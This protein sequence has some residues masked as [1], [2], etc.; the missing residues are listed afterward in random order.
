MTFQIHLEPGGKNF[1]AEP[2]EKIL[3]AALRQGVTLPY[4]CRNGSCGTCKAGLK[5]GQVDYGQ[6][7]QKA[8]TEAERAAGKVLLCQARALSD[9]TVEAQE[10]VTP[11]GI[12]IKTLPARVMKMERA[13]HDVMVLSLKL[14]EN[15]RLAF[16][17]GQYIE[18]LLKDNQR[19]SFSLANPPH[20]DEFLELH[21]RHVPG[22]FFTE[23]VFTKMQ[24][25]DLLRFRG[26]LGT[27]FLRE[28]SQRPIILVAGGT[29]FAPIQ[30]IVEHALAKNINRPMHLYWG[31]RAGRDLYRHALCESWAQAHPHIRY[32]PVLSEP[33]AEDAWR[34]RTGWVHEAVAADHT[35]M[36]GIEVYASGPPPMIEAIKRTFFA[37]GL[38]P[39]NLFFDSFEFAHVAP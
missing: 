26:P 13:A 18:I 25:R 6:Y 34:G 33:T 24:E 29:G 12:V 35:D 21:V 10:V 19:R 23:H 38:A 4:S 5:A 1:A 28:E 32:T 37:R 14:P 22:G 9:V 31:A 36:S 2:N 39:E 30:A 7:E 20:A 8:M 15:Q 27:F 11:A 16:L 17:A 3:E